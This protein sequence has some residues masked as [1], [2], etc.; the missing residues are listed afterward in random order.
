[1]VAGWGKCSGAL[2]LGLQVLEPIPV[3]EARNFTVL[4]PSLCDQEALSKT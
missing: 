3:C 4:P 2:M 1:M